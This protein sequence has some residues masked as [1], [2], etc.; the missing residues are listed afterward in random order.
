[1]AAATRSKKQSN[2]TAVFDFRY[3][4]D[5]FE[6]ARALRELLK[7]IAKSYT[8]QQERGDGGYEHWQGRLS[9]FKRRRKMAALHLFPEGKRPQYLEPTSNT[10]FLKGD[11]FYM[12]KVDTRIDGPWTDKD[13]EPPPLT[14]Q[15]ELL[16]KWGLRP[17]QLTLRSMATE[18]DLRAIDLIYCPNGNNGKSL[19]S[20]HMEYVQL[21]EEIP[22]FRLMDDIFQWVASRPIQKCYIVDMPRGMKKDRL[23]DFYSGLEVIKNGVAFDKRYSAKK[24]RFTRPRIFV[25]TNQLPVFSLMSIDR[26]NIWTITDVTHKLEKH[27]TYFKGSVATTSSTN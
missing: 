16:N 24:K 14:A 13:L 12:M 10:E 2:E 20:E 4:L 19:F 25:F 6:D 27:R 15:M 22:P 21:A 11:A 18:F 23:G 8:F 7:G 1:M 5:I 9:L 3:N 17:W 26:W